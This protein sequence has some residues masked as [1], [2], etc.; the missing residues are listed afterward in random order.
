M[1]E[2]QQQQ[3]QQHATTTS[4]P[5]PPPFLK[6][7][8]IPIYFDE[9]WDTGIGGGLWSTG[10]AIAKYFQHNSSSIR[11][12]L[13][14]IHNKHRLL[15]AATK[16][17]YTDIGINIDIDTAGRGGLVEVG[18]TALELGSGN[19]FLSICLAA[20]AGDILSELVITDMEDHLALIETTVRANAHIVTMEQRRDEDGDGDGDGD[21]DADTTQL[22]ESTSNLQCCIMEHRW[23][24]FQSSNTTTT[25][26]HK[27]TNADGIR[28]QVQNGTKKFD[29][30]FGSD[31]A[32]RDHLHAPLIASLDKFSH[33]HTVSLIGVTMH[34]TKPIF[35]SALVEA[36]FTYDR[37][38]DHLM[39]E[40]FRGTTFGLFVI[41]RRRGGRS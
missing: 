6:C 34:D 15:M 2:Q 20:I 31:V 10:L 27:N 32:Y 21:G 38:A 14:N 7:N 39:S 28:Q 8:N 17:T 4:P 35:F 25:T 24:E 11:H 29:F 33:A 18:M 41:R 16:N 5:P 19:G 30:I 23:G 36:G 40:E 13:I 1:K 3:Q 9:N 22:G 12:S 26:N 37:I